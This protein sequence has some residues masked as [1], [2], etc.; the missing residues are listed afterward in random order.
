[1]NKA[2]AMQQ[3]LQG[4]VLDVSPAESLL[5]QEK[6]EELEQLGFAL[7]P[8]GKRSYVLK[9]IP[10]IF[11]KVQPKELLHDVL[12]TLE[13]QKNSLEK[14]QEAII[15]RMACRASVKAGD[16]VSIP[17]MEKL[18]AELEQCILPYTCPHG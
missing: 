16:E 6:R 13:E 11:G 10:T 12:A 7:E 5:M 3:L 14:A 2:V 9:T 15:T 1:M 18:L 8:F 4:E 17:Q